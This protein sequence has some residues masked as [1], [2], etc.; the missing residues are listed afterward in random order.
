MGAF[1][2]QM[3][4]YG[5]GVSPF[6]RG[7]GS[8]EYVDVSPRHRCPVCGK[9]SWCQVKRDGSVVLCKNIGGTRS[10]ENRDGVTFHIHPAE[11]SMRWQPPPMPPAQT[12]ARASADTCD[13]GY[14]AALASLRLD[15]VDRAGLLARGLDEATIRANGYRTLSDRG[16]SEVARAVVDAVGDAEAPGVPGVFWKEGDEGRGWWSF[17]G[18]SGLLIPV[19]D[20]DGRIVALKV[21]R[22]TIE[23]GEKRYVYITSSSKG[24]PSAENALH[25]P[26]AARGLRATG[27]LVITEG[28]LKADVATHLLGDWPVVSIPG[29]G[30]WSKAVEFARAWGAREVAVAFDGD[31]RTN[32]V[33]NLA[34]R[35]LL[36]AL[37]AA[38][39]PGVRAWRWDAKFKGIDD[40]LAAKRRGEVTA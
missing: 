18:W 9:S 31:W 12:S 40:Y 20:L 39:W 6:G 23:E 4:G 1:K 35:N 27:R 10:K 38:G 34:E 7:S 28:E 14:R 16:R 17:S 19:R 26:S 29:V 37:R 30:A 8:R 15:D 32:K 33:V 22:R 21:R 13:A 3:S 5:P 24:G 11:G 25:V 36:H 2:E